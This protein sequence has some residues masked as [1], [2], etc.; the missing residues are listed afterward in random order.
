MVCGLTAGGK[1]IRTFGPAAFRGDPISAV[2]DHDFAEM[3]STFEMAICLLR[4]GKRERPIYHGA[5]AVHR[6]Y[7]VHGLEIDP[8]SDADRTERNTAAGQQ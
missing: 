6:N 3:H 2:C 8:T 1:R 5:Q 7:P 4:L